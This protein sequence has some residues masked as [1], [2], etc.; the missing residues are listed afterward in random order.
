[1]S[2]ITNTATIRVVAD[3]SGVEGG[4]RTAT[5]AAQRAGQAVSQVGAGA[6][7]AARNVESAQRNIVA[8]IQR[9]TIAMESG[10]RQSAAYYE[11]LARQRGIDPATLAPYLNQL[12]AIEQAQVRTGA[13][14]AQVANAMRM[15]PAQLG[16]IASQL[17]GGQSPLLILMQQ[18]SQLRDS[19]G[20]I[21][22]TLRG[23]GSTLLGLVN[24]FAVA[25]GA[26][27]GLIYAF[28]KA[29][30]ETEAYNRA[31]ILS[32]NT[33]GTTAG[34]LQ[35]MARQISDSVGTQGQAAAAL[36]A[37]AG[38]GK[39]AAENLLE[40]GRSAIEMQRGLGQSAEDTAKQFAELGKSPV[41][42]TI[43]LNEQYHYL[44]ASVLEQ[45]RALD[46][47]G[48]SDEAAS[49]AQK[50]YASA[51]SDRMKQVK[52]SLGTVQTAWSKVGDAAGKAWDQFLNIGRPQTIDEQ[53]AQIDA[54]LA[55]A[56]E[57]V[58]P[59]ASMARLG[60][61]QSAPA[62]DKEALE[63]KR[64]A[65]VLQKAKEEWDA[66]QKAISQQFN[67]ALI[68]W[69]KDGDKYLT[70]I[71]KRDQ[72]IK[73]VREQGIAAGVSDKAIND[74]VAKI[75]AEYSSLDNPVLKGLENQRDQQREILK[76]Q[77]E[78]L[79]SHHK[80]QLVSESD[81]VAKKRDLQVQEIDLEV[82][83]L[84][85]KAQIDAGKE[86]KS[87]RDK[88]LS[89]LQV[90]MIKRRNIIQA[91]DNEIAEYNSNKTKAIDNLVEGWDRAIE[92]Q[93]HAVEQELAMFGQSDQARKVYAAQAQID[94]DIRKQIAAQIKI[95]QPLNEQDIAT[96]RKRAEVSKENRA[97]AENELAALA[98]ANQLRRDNLKFS[99]EYIADADLRA[100]RL[101]EIDAEQWQYLINNTAEGSEARKKILE[102][103]DVWMANRQMQPVLDRWKGV[104]DNLDNNFQ[105]GFR[106]MLT[107]G[108][109][110][111]SSFAKSIGNTLKT[112]LAD[113]LYQTFVKRYVVQIVASLAGAISGPAVADTLSGTGVPGA[114]AGVPGVSSAISAAQ[115]ASSLYKAI[116]GGFDSLSTSV[117]DAVQA[118]LYK[119]GLSPNI[120][121]NG[122]F[123]TSVGEYASSGAGALAG[124]Y[125]GN[126]IAGDYSIN[127]GQAVTNIASV[128]GA[129]IGGPIGGA[130]GG[131]IGGLINRAFG[132][133][134]K[135]IGDT[136]ISGSITA[137]GLTASSYAKYHQDGGWFRSDKNGTD[138]KSL[139]ADALAAISNGLSQIK[140]V[141]SSFA[142]SIG[143]DAG[144]I[145]SYSKQF[146][147]ALGKDGKI[148]EGVTKLLS[149]V[150]DELA[151]RLVPNI[152]QFTKSGE[153]ASS[154][155]E[156]LASDFTATT[157]MAQLLGKTAVEAF[158]SAG[159]ASAATRE[160]L[161]DLAGSASNLTSWASSYAQN[162]L[163]EQE[164][165]A[166][167]K[168]AVDEAMSSLGLASVT[169]RD[170]F[171]RVV[172]S[173]DLTT[174]A[175]AKQF[176]SMMQL[177]DAFAQV[178]AATET[179]TRTE[180]DIA[181]ERAGLQDQLDQLT[182]TSTQLLKKQRD[183]LAEANRPLF[184]MVQTAQKLAD[185]SSSLKTFRD[186]VRSLS[187]S[188]STGSLSV[189]TP[190]QQEAELKGQYEK[191]RAAAMG[192]DT[193]AQGKFS[194]A[195]TAWLT[196]SQKLNAGD[197]Q[198][199]ADFARGQQDAAAAAAWATGQIDT[200][201]AQLN[202]MNSQT[203]AM[204]AVNS[205]LTTTNKILDAIAQNT[206]P[207]PIQS[208]F[209]LS[210]ALSILSSAVKLLKENSDKQQQEV[211]GLRKDQQAQTGEAI[212]SNAEAQQQNA[213]TIVSGMSLLARV[214]AS[215][216][217]V[218][219]E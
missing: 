100:R 189:L 77:L 207:A 166:P 7:G 33:A 199:Q 187:D 92:A 186:S 112:A 122:S 135:E 125:I 214:I 108:K 148:E 163:T 121:S 16:D 119:T 89:D 38:T 180:S 196:A 47:Q 36:A 17:A 210:N 50:T 26:A 18:G 80:Q 139:S 73:K 66:A 218:T 42:A 149:S 169:T 179:L 91:A 150:G 106:D 27:A 114:A 15:V 28:H 132:M 57:K 152:A 159:L 45:I 215:N 160:R 217:K 103:F 82:N 83:L 177:A 62:V 168:K 5:Q 201:Q 51:L 184:D 4:L 193:T 43:K 155:L 76:G 12:R 116:T 153:T 170:E 183:A 185:T 44:T 64:A 63:Q 219:L 137:G 102:Q 136:G 35:V 71:Q 171:K 39:V 197:T 126:A 67:D 115:T 164:K 24:P 216:Q 142:A 203:L 118:G 181:S 14:S 143:A 204:Q 173:L 10:G 178:H 127:H 200:A 105:E 13:S 175:G 37:L 72:E 129:I 30:Q 195:L 198:Y 23:V 53:I 134:S 19:F 20:S 151:T 107:S 209:V 194:D 99:A 128:A 154:T 101:M 124:H 104:I 188:L 48:Q 58:A 117:A 85:K 205:S 212:A 147:I 182:M 25:A 98:A 75:Y 31:I 113:A 55:R 46:K 61:A 74:R 93:S 68:Q 130:I 131:A 65:L 95:N 158:G 133:G 111:W 146:D 141:S 49:L 96:L 87:E 172:A 208:G 161:V 145:A 60:F 54:Q 213:Q 69:D 2:E 176:T 6:G 202:S 41:D 192:G 32:G 22:A 109:S 97:E 157:Q 79:E 206:S 211:A 88:D 1:M 40:F 140:A 190:E 156:R 165:L 174:E 110:A 120:A 138:S 191:I 11:A 78:D 56:K 162:Y 123:A 21:P 144:S 167:V 81:Y 59:I 52:E 9:T 34:Q 90:A 8:A 3:A 29:S 94:L 84:R 86:D 70:K